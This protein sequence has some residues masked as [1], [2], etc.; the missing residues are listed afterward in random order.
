MSILFETPKAHPGKKLKKWPIPARLCGKDGYSSQ[1]KVGMRIA[2]TK[3]TAWRPTP[4]VV[5][6][7]NE[8][9]LNRV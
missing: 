1:D 5:T 8:R 2:D 9:D 3:R 7:R 6:E 4:A